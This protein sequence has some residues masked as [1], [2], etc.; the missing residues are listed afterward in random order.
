MHPTTSNKSSNLPLL[1]FDEIRADM[2]AIEKE[3]GGLLN[4]IIGGHAQ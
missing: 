2:L 3:A 4:E 1:T